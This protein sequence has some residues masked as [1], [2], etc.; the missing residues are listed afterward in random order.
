[1]IKQILKRIVPIALLKQGFLVYNKIRIRT[2]DKFLYPEYKVP[3]QAFTIYREDFP[4][5]VNRTDISLLSHRAEYPYMK[6]WMD[7]TLDEYLLEFKTDCW[8]EPKY[9]WA[10]VPPNKLIYESLA[11]SRTAHQ[12]KPDLIKFSRRKEILVLDKAISL[13]DGGEENYFHFYND[14]LSKLFYLKEKGIDVTSYSIIVSR[15]LYDKPYFQYY[16]RNVEFLRSLV[17]VVQDVQYIQCKSVIF[18]KP[19][20][21]SASLW[22]AFVPRL[23]V[24]ETSLRIFLTRNKSRLRFLENADEIEAVCKRHGIEMVDADNL[25]F[26]KQ[27]A[28]FAQASLIIGIHGAGLT[29]MIYRNGESQV[30]EIFPPPDL[31]YLPYHYILLA[32]MK[33]FRYRALIGGPGRIPYSGGF[34]LD[35][36]Q[37]EKE[38]LDCLE[39]RPY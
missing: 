35:V 5:R 25:S 36:G 39:T 19:M 16:I 37:F 28:L 15:R 11:F 30:M 12:R 4:F 22:N 26:E 38:V 18:C 1:M 31:G 10:I 21:H 24:P 33:K 9:G 13:R 27:I 29:N 14:I 23:S 34:C 32:G 2:I 17:W 7:W 3:R 8:I 20:T 6:A